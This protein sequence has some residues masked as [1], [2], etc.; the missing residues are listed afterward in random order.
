MIALR[1]NFGMDCLPL[2]FLPG[3]NA[4]RPARIGHTTGVTM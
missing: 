2:R 1:A 3:I 4:C